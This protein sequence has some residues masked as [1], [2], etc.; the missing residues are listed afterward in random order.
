MWFII[1]PSN[2]SGIYCL[3]SQLF[4]HYWNNLFCMIST[5]W[6]LLRLVLKP[7]IIHSEQCSM[8]LRWICNLVVLG[9]CSVDML[10][11]VGPECVWY[12]IVLLILFLDILLIIENRELKC[13]VIVFK[14]SI[15]HQFYEF[16]F[17]VLWGSRVRY[18]FVFN[19]YIF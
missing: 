5:I 16:I 13:P 10:D 7:D 18:I 8:H 1:L 6:N 2:Y 15:Y 11:L 4:F 9:D 17:Y 19:M 12:F 14:S 3:V